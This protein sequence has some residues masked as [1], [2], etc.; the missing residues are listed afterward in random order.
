[1]LRSAGPTDSADTSSTLAGEISSEARAKK[2]ADEDRDIQLDIMDK[3]IAEH[4]DNAAAYFIRGSLRL[5]KGNVEAGIADLT[6]AVTLDPKYTHAYDKRGF[7]RLKKGDIEGAVE[8]FDASIRQ[9]RF[10]SDA[11]RGRADARMAESKFD[12]AL[13]DYNKAIELDPVDAQAFKGRGDCKTRMGDQKGA[14][15][16]YAMARKFGFKHGLEAG[17]VPAPG[18]H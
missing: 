8:D 9:N 16:D 10:S 7:A 14:N 3:R 13:L 4:D 18:A 17:I 2:A 12:L 1:M 6:K 5:D 15:E 11:F